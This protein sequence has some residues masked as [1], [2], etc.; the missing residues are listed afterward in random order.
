MAGIKRSVDERVEG[1]GRKAMKTEFCGTFLLRGEQCGKLVGKGGEG[2]AKLRKDFNVDLQMPGARTSNRVFV[3]GGA[4]D[5]CV[6]AMK[7][8]LQHCKRA[9]FAVGHKTQVDLN[10]LIDTDTVGRIVGKGGSKA[11]EIREQTNAKMK[12]YQE[13]LPNSN[14]RVVA[15]GGDDVE[16]IAEALKLVFD[17]VIENP[18]T[19]PTFHYDPGQHPA[20]EMFL[21]K[22][23]EYTPLMKNFGQGQDGFLAH[24]F[25]IAETQSVLKL[26]NEMCGY[27]IGHGGL[28]IKEIRQTSG[29]QI[30]FSEE[31]VVTVTEGG[32]VRQRSMTISG[33]QA[34]VQAA[35]QLMTECVRNAMLP[36]NMYTTY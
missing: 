21:E 10:M 27:I 13:C 7:E 33:S 24:D 9:P 30:E 1:S 18:K 17:I 26:S 31:K 34:Q 20:T 35:E 15:I 3:I 4:R 28:K 25:L 8:V 2:L 12:I 6:K 23:V 19:T 36:N 11:R 29:A 22:P 32:A 16:D 5:D 14:E